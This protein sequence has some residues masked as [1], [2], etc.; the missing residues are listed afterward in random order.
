MNNDTTF[1]R[2]RLEIVDL[3]HRYAHHAD[4]G[5]LDAFVALFSDDAVLDM[6]LPG[7]H[8][9]AS[10]ALA[11]KNRPA[12]AAHTQTRHVMTNLVFHEQSTE[13]ASGALYFTFISSTGGKPALLLT[14]QYSFTVGRESGQWRIRRWRVVM[15]GAP[16]DA[17]K[18]VQ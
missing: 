16:N 6:A 9:K 17:E 8:D 5:E 1:I 12:P 10:L 2:D 15:D 4:G 13:S 14:G 11:M 3:I 18:G 7:V